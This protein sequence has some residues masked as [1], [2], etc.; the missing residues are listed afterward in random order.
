MAKISDL[1]NLTYKFNTVTIRI[2]AC[3]FVDVCH[4]PMSFSPTLLF[5]AI[6]WMDHNHLENDVRHI[7]I[8]HALQNILCTL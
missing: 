8:T 3:Y 2:L 1:P 7:F 6:Y 5:M 4:K